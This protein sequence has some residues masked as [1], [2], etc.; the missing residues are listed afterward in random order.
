MNKEIK[1]KIKIKD[2]IAAIIFI[3]CIGLWR[4]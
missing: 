1:E 3:A 2:W 4:R